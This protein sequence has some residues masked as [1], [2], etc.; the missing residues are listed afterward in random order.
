MF[1]LRVL[2]QFAG[3]LL[4]ETLD[5]RPWA[6]FNSRVHSS[7]WIQVSDVVPAADDADDVNVSLK[8]LESARKISPPL[9]GMSCTPLAVCFFVDRDF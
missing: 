2:I 9:S 7:L 6:N 4:N 3:W 5:G 1:I 8:W